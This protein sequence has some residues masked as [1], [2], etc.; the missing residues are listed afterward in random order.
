MGWEWAQHVPRVILGTSWALGK[1]RVL[2]DGKKPMSESREDQGTLSSLHSRLIH[3]SGFRA[4]VRLTNI[5][6]LDRV[7]LTMDKI[8]LS[9][10]LLNFFTIFIIFSH[11]SI[12][13]VCLSCCYL[14]AKSCLTLCNS[15][16]WSLQISSV[17]GIS[18]ARILEWVD[19]LSSRGSSQPRDWTWVSCIAGR[20]VSA[21]LPALMPESMCVSCSVM[22]NSLRSHGQVNCSPPSSSVHGILQARILEWVAI[23]FSRGIFLTQG[24][25]PGLLNCRQIH[26]HLSRKA[27]L[28][29][30]VC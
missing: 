18:Q 7:N 9:R 10:L 22:F 13:Y 25:N 27:L 19:I 30:C 24:S 3:S 6:P 28:L 2:G 12:S 16:H 1:F 21:E 14:V 4:H 23:L 8:N 20:F 11:L 26:Y 5:I 17:H 15:M 29:V